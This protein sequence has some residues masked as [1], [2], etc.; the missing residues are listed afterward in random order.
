L[1]KFA[2]KADGACCRSYGSYED[3]C[4]DSEVDVIYVST[5]HIKHLEHVKMC[6][7]HGKHVLCEKP[8]GL[9]E[10]Q[11]REMFD[12][13]EA[14]G[15]LCLEAMWT[16]Y[17]PLVKDIQSRL[18]RGD[19][20]AVVSVSA[21]IGFARPETDA[22]GWNKE[23]GGGAL[24][25]NGVYGVQWA[26]LAL[27]NGAVRPTCVAAAVETTGSSLGDDSKQQS[28]GTAD[29]G[30]DKQGAVSLRFPGQGVA[31]VAWSHIGHMSNEVR[32]SGTKGFIRV[33]AP[34]H[35]PT[36]ADVVVHRSR[37]E[38]DVEELRA[39]LPANLSVAKELVFPNSQGLQHQA[40]AIEEL[41]VGVLADGG[42]K[43]AVAKAAS[44]AAYT[45]SEACAVSWICDEIR[46][47]HGIKYECEA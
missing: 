28:G 43:D 2:L 6:L 44:A 36:S 41:L 24:L 29:A 34:A 14:K 13:A 27:G 20:G 16:R 4:R 42:G 19:I 23:L 12:L 40:R 37:T 32:I 11:C 39:P 30:I 21:D 1:G 18:Q 45:P 9:N 5:L 46:R 22:R 31:A 26:A 15:L 47:S 38:K 17:F 3:L 35:C 33:H 25:W 7:Q 8:L 10:A